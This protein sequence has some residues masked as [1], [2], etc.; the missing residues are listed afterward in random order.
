MPTSY[1]P[2]TKGSTT[3]AKRTASQSVNSNT[4]ETTATVGQLLAEKNT[5]VVSVTPQD[6]LQHAV[7]VLRDKRIG[8]L[9]VT[10]DAGDLCGILSERD[11]VRKLAETPGQTLAQ[12]VEENM[13]RDVQ[14]CAPQDALIGVLRQMTEGRFRHMPVVDPQGG[15]NR[16]CGMIT[17][18][19]VIQFRL[20]TL[21]HEAL[22]M[23]QLIVG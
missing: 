16:L 3:T 12:S 11:I 18:G 19:D 17:I 14:T 20:R 23:K 21:E 5:D 7:E 22:Q 13:T 6:S 2:P 10:D 15:T 9:V 1:Q 4:F 8:A